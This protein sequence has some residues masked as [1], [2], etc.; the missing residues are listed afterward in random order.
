MT[1]RKIC[2][3][4]GTRAEYGL[5]SHL[6]SLI[7]QSQEFDLQIIA[8]GMHLS[9]KFGLTYKD[10]EKDG[11]KIDY[12][13]DIN[14]ISDT[15]LGLSSSTAIALKEISRA[16]QDLKPDLVLI[17]GDRFEI[18]AS[19]IAAMFNRIPIAHI[20]GGERAEGAIDEAIRHSITKISHFHFV[21]A[22][23]YKKRVIQLGELPDKVFMVGGLGV[24][25][26]KRLQLMD[27][28][29]LED[30][31]G[32]KFKEKNLLI[33]F[34][35]VTLEEYSSQDQMKELMKSLTSLKDTQLIFTM[36]NAD[37]DSSIL[38]SM[39]EDF[40]LS[41]NNAYSFTSLGHL[42]YLSCIAQVDGVVGN[43]SSGISEVPSFCKGTINIGH[44]QDGRLR[45]SSII[46]CNPD[47][48]SII[49]AIDNLYS[50]SFQKSLELTDNP[51]GEGGASQKIIQILEDASF[52]DLLMKPFYDLS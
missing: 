30:S 38:F 39:I 27:K 21:A 41:N 26:I 45:A 32:L 10:I 25:S 37:T 11:F 50:E 23:E 28:E 16:Y 15:P 43:S 1:K 29:E 49:K 9:E 33:T 48:N 19:A 17:L 6:I 47:K 31:L 44:R 34:H 7:E 51:Y 8:T 36:P 24:D 40:V 12:K 3:V 4:T 2:V 35:P 42:R 13:I 5:L 22:E 52:K 18:F 46:D 20:S 14:L